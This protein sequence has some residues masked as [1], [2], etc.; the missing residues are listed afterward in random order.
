MFQAALRGTDPWKIVSFSVYGGSL[1][2]LYGASASYHTF[3]ISD[4]VHRALR[5]FDHCMVYFLIAGSYTPLCLIPLRGPV[6]WTLLSIVWGLAI[7]GMIIKLFWLNG[8]MWASSVCYLALGGVI[9]SL[10]II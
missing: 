9:L 3:Y 1:V 10:I 2:L 4:C 5:K 8:P 6:G 7:I